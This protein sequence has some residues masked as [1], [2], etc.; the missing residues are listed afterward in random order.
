MKTTAIDTCFV[1]KNTPLYFF[2]ELSIE[3]QAHAAYEKIDAELADEMASALDYYDNTEFSS[4][5]EEIDYFFGVVNAGCN[6]YGKLSINDL[7]NMAL[8]YFFD[9][10]V[11]VIYRPFNF[12]YSCRWWKTHE[13]YE[14]TLEAVIEANSILDNEEME[15]SAEWL[16]EREYEAKTICEFMDEF[17]LD[18]FAQGE[19]WIDECFEAPTHEDM[20]FLE[21]G[22]LFC[23][24]WDIDA[25]NSSDKV[26]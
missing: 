25:Y 21:S 4:S 23:Q 16:K 9:E 13:Y 3:A 22:E 12:N 7:A 26:A 20:L 24:A 14:T 10:D 6:V 8:G 5:D 2:E 18:L 15:E 11:T 1:P 19:A 17:G